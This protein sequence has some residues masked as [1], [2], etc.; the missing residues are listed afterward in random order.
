M[1]KHRNASSVVLALIVIAILACS[2]QAIAKEVL[3]LRADETPTTVAFVTTPTRAMFTPVATPTLMP[4]ATASPA[5]SSALPVAPAPT[6]LPALNLRTDLPALAL[7]DWPRPAND[8]GRGI[9]FFADRVYYTPRDFEIQMPRVIDLQMR[10]MLVIYSD[11]NQMRLAAPQFKAAG[12][13]P[14]W[15]RYLRAYNRYSS[16]ERDVQI[17]KEHG[18]PPYFQ[19]YNEP[20]SEEEWDGRPVNRDAWVATFVQSARDV[21]NAGGFVGLQVLDPEWVRAVIQEIKTRQ[22]ERIFGRMFFVPHAYALNH[23]PNYTEDEN[24]VLGFR[25]FADVFQK[26]LGF[27]PPFI[28]GEGGW[29]IG[30][31]HDNRFP[32]VD[33]PLIAK[34][35]VELYNWFRPPGRM[36][37][38]EPL[39]DYLF[40]FCPWLLASNTT[41][42]A[43]Y[44]SFEGNRTALIQSVTKMGTFTRQFSWD[45]K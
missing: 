24:A 19:L 5:P 18:L 1:R 31:A 7:R 45:K 28:V 44:D 9:H 2:P 43:W 20:D 38:G 11:E 22:G 37:N 15:R 33:E 34:Y 30:E 42:G 17:L 12:I 27:V 8:N 35:Y 39:P 41:A 40:A 16:W 13:V 23:P 6:A 14:V 4:P 10:W 32:K 3:G 21:Y 36:S 29:K 25:M 26:E